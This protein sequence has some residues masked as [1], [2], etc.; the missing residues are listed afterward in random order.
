MCNAIISRIRG[1]LLVLSQCGHHPGRD[2]LL[3]GQQRA[4]LGSFPYNDALEHEKVNTSNCSRT[5]VAYV[6]IYLD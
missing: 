4:V 5:A 2:F 1:E 3:F 6:D